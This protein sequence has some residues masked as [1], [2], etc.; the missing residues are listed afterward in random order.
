MGSAMG[1]DEGLLCSVT[2]AGCGTAHDAHER[3]VCE[4]TKPQCEGDAALLE[5]KEADMYYWNII[6]D[7]SLDT[8]SRTVVV[9]MLLQQGQKVCFKAG[10]SDYMLNQQQATSGPKLREFD[11]EEV[12]CEGS[13]IETTPF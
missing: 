2:I 11:Y 7:F 3:V 4:I 9:P 5:N 13:L 6:G 10:P 8:M 1:E 12:P